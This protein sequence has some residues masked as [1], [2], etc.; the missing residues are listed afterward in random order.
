MTQDFWITFSLAV[1]AS[2]RVT[3]LLS[4]EDG[5]GD[6][7]VRLRVR[8][9]QGLA[10]QLMDCFNCLS[11]WVAAFAAFFVSRKPMGWTFSWL[12]L[13]GAAC[14]LE[15]LGQESVTIQRAS[16]P[17]DGEVNHVLRSETISAAEFNDAGN[18]EGYRPESG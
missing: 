15:R 10:G 14:L 4:S 16:Q 17:R 18:N 2:W 1:L 3:R 12:A 13:S 9:G 11:L 6:L 8:L 7:I 5:P